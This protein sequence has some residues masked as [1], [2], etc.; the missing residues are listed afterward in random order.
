MIYLTFIQE[1]LYI[2][3]IFQKKKSS[4]LLL[5]LLHLIN[6]AFDYNTG[7]VNSL[8]SAKLY[9]CL[10]LKLRW[11]RELERRR[12][13]NDYRFVFCFIINVSMTKMVKVTSIKDQL[14]W[15]GLQIQVSLEATAIVSISNCLL[16]LP[17]NMRDSDCCA[18]KP[19]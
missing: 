3:R 12:W 5:I 9:Y 19:Q 17:K 18:K 13:Q 14:M 1:I 6:V 15:C 11:W 10:V 8:L 16:Q 2:F 4:I 7:S